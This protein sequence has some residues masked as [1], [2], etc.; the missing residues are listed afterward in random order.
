M[1]YF[2]LKEL[3]EIG[4]SLRDYNVPSLLGFTLGLGAPSQHF[5]KDSK[6]FLWKCP[7]QNENDLALSKMKFQAWSRD[8]AMGKKNSILSELTNVIK[9]GGTFIMKTA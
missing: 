8:P 3:Y 2:L 4:I 5:T 7:L 9:D 6:I 1:G